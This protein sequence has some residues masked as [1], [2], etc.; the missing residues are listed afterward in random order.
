VITP[1]NP[2]DDVIRSAMRHWRI[3]ALI[4]AAITLLAWLAAA[5]Q[6]K[7]YRAS[8]L[9]A[10]NPLTEQLT[11]SDVIRG[12]DTLDRRVVVASIAALASAPNI[13]SAAGASSG[14]KIT[15]V[16]LPNT[17]LFRIEVEGRDSR[18]AAAIANKLPALLGVQSRTIYKMYGVMLVS[19]ATA[20][21]KAV[22]PRVGRA[23]AAGLV[24]GLLLGVAIAWVLDRMR[25]PPAVV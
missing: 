7:R 15:A 19:P 14:Y 6:P 1:V 13:V 23:V 2:A 3:V 8:A 17:S 9:A 20:S 12:I 16:V 18:T 11:P 5:T 10:I 25:R 4:A 22:L 24:L 21:D